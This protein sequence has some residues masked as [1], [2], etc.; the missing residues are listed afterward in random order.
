MLRKNMIML[1]FVVVVI[2]DFVP[3]ISFNY[4]LACV[5]LFKVEEA[6]RVTK[7]SLVQRDA[8]IHN[9]SKL[10]A[11]QLNMMQEIDLSVEKLQRENKDLRGHL[12]VAQSQLEVEQHKWMQNHH[13]REQQHEQQHHQREQQREQHQQYQRQHEDAIDQFPRY[14]SSADK[15]TQEE[16][17]TSKKKS[18]FRHP[19]SDNNG[20]NDHNS[21]SYIRE[22]AHVHEGYGD[23]QRAAD[24]N[25]TSSS[26]VFG[27]RDSVPFFVGDGDNRVTRK[28]THEQ[29]TTNVMSASTL[30]D[31]DEEIAALKASLSSLMTQAN[32]N[33][34]T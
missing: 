22:H 2:L 4:V 10:A 5:N 6:L 25:S 27:D 19:H 30:T 23:I 20:N 13:Q 9:L 8:E 12:A 26:E 1:V 21:I 33:T 17:L 29:P 16:F 15:A 14:L 7:L 18:T 32:V 3:N 34:S 31:I 24:T 11:K 28:W